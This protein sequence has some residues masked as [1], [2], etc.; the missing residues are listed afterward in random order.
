[1]SDDL[2][3]K[4]QR[5]G[6]S[7]LARSMPDFVARATKGRLSPQA[8]IEELVRCEAEER[9]RRGVERRIKG[10]R[11]GRF[12]PLADFDWSWP[13]VLPREAIERLF[14]LDF[15]KEPAN[16]I[17]VGPAGVGK[18][19]I[20]KN[21]AQAATMAGHTTLFVEAAD[22]LSDLEQQDSPR[23]LRMRLRKY[24]RPALLAIDEIGFLSFSSR[25]A[26]LMF[27]VVNKR[28]ET[29]ST[30]LTTN[31][32]FKDWPTIFPGAACVVAMLERLTHRAEIIAIDGASYRMR[33]AEARRTPA[34]S[35]TPTTKKPPRSKS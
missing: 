19:M 12:R 4:M 28:Y 14:T 8:M 6:L 20:A 22:M 13:K 1:M 3:E 24:T 31:I 11:I 5:L 16:V 32:A 21:L 29:G 34:P 15:I 26:D 23:A 35:K 30:V 9:I 33:E 7:Y 27:Q 17:L 2:T 25:A 18:T 10:A